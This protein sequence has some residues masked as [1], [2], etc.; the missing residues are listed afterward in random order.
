MPTAAPETEALALRTP[1]ASG[2]FSL[3]PT[4]LDQA[5]TFSEQM[6]KADL[7]PAHLRAK[8]ADCLRVILLACDWHM[9]PFAVADK[10]SVINGKLMFEGQLVAAIVNARGDL[11]GR[12]RYDFAGEKALRVL[13]VS[14]TLRGETTPRTITLTHEQAA[15]INKNGQI[16][17]NPDQQMC[18]I[19]S[20]IWARRHTP[21]LLLGVY[22]DDEMPEADDLP[23][24]VTGTA[25]NP[26]AGGFTGMPPAEAP[27]PT[28]R[29]PMPAGRRRRGA[30]AALA[31]G[32]VDVPATTPVT[33]SQQPA[34]AAKPAVAAP[35]AA[36]TPT[37][38]PKA[39]T[40]AET[41][42][43]TPPPAEAPPAESQKTAK[44]CPPLAPGITL[45]GYHGKPWPQVIPFEV[46]EVVARRK[47]RGNK[48]PYLEFLVKAAGYEGK[49]FA[50]NPEAGPKL[51][52]SDDAGNLLITS[53]IIHAGAK[54]E[55]NFTATPRGGPGGPDY[56]RPPLLIISAIEVLRETFF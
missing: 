35:P 19:G 24:N 11:A 30:A 50:F 33:E 15:R 29:P 8:P 10:T 2:A 36:A 38:P 18:Y 28:A 31:E 41:K 55:G 17:Q 39:A 22:A 48:D 46:V 7:L 42:A 47:E 34:E 40:P 14:G 21:E 52:N 43:A 32:A 26:P 56:S 44:D 49:A 27:A 9:N 4:S 54:L 1:A 23:R 51:V 16:N 53:N 45:A 13:T 3:I 20:R 37:E 5:I 12:L 6:A 25:E